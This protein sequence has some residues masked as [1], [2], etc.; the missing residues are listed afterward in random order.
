MSTQESEVASTL[1][2]AHR[3]QGH[4]ACHD[5]LPAASST[6]RNLVTVTYTQPPDAWLEPWHDCV[7]EPFDRHALVTVGERRV[8]AQNI[9]TGP[10]VEIIDHPEDFRATSA[11]VGWILDSWDGSDAR[12]TVCFDSLGRLLDHA[13]PPAVSRYLE[14]LTSRIQAS[15]ATLHFHL[16]P[17]ACEDRTLEALESV[18]D[19]VVGPDAR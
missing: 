12:S 10:T 11:A 5:Q 7:D 8:S 19:A 14:A 18:F 6:D 16:D 3:G 1:V 4:R 9:P 17:A 15:G 2:L 13:D